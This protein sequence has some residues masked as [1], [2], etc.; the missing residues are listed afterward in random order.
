MGGLIGTGAPSLS[1]IVLLFEL[2][3]AALL[4]A[5]IFVVRRGHVRAHMYLQS[6]VVL[7]NLPVVLLWMLPQ[8]LSLVLPDL[9]SEFSSPNYYVPTAMLIAGLLAESLGVFILLVAG[10]NLIPERFRFRRY[11]LWMRTEVALWW[12]VLLLGL[13][14]YYIWYA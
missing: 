4:L 11:K 5:G 10:T 8:Y 1:D 14:T 3:I 6:S 7:V 13:S 9:L 2:T 12:G